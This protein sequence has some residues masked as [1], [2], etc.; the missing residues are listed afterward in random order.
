MAFQLTVY[1]CLKL[2]YLKFHKNQIIVIAINYVGCRWTT[3]SNSVCILGLI[4]RKSFIA[5]ELSGIIWILGLCETPSSHVNF[6][7]WYCWFF[8]FTLFFPLRFPLFLP[9]PLSLSFPP[10]LPFFSSPLLALSSLA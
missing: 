2:Y 1:N 3:F 8:P 5:S 9:F 7:L 4:I 10:F 6:S